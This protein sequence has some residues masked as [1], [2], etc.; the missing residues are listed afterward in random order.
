VSGA[1]PEVPL[2]PGTRVVG[3]LHLDVEDAAAVGRFTAWAEGARGAPRLVIL[4]DLF[5]YWVGASQLA[6]AE[7]AL[8]AL[9]RLTAAGARIDVV[10]G[11][12]DFL[13]DAS[14]ESRTG[15][16]V[17]PRGFVGRLRE[18]VPPPA[19][20]VLF[21]HGDE[22]CTLDRPYQRLRRVLR[23]GPVRFLAPRL[24]AP[25]AR[26]AARRLRRASRSSVDAKPRASM[27]LQPDACRAVA[28]AHGC[29]TVVCGHAHRFRDE[30]IEDGVR[31]LVVDAFGGERDTLVVGEDGSIGPPLAESVAP[32]GA[33]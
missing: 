15:A 7:P 27:E 5:E 4:G 24:P 32:R 22:L 14:F 3:D 10:P 11:N 30:V 19:A 2:E 31:W 23:S 21:L 17:R 29:G 9:A 1:L 28:R 8:A 20:R 33:P 18:D 16:C 12:R 26:A 6:A 13:L 25:V